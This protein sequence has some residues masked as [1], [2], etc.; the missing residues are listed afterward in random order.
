MN[1]KTNPWLLIL[2][3]APIPVVLFSFLLLKWYRQSDEFARLTSQFV[4]RQNSVLAY[5]AGEVSTGV[6]DLLEK[7]ARDVEILSLLPHDPKRYLQFHQLQMSDFTQFTSKADVPIQEP[8]NFYNK[9]LYMTLSGEFSIF[10][11]RGQ[12]APTPK[13]LAACRTKDLC[14]HDLLERAL[15]LSVGQLEYGHLMRYY[16]P[17]SVPEDANNASW[18]IAYHGKDGIYFLGLDY[19]HLRDHM[20]TPSFP[21]DSKRDLMQSYQNGNYIYLVDADYNIFVHPKYW[22]SYGLDR[23][24]GLAVPSM[25]TDADE[26]KVFINIANYQSGRLKEYFNRLLTRSF[27]QKGV[28]IF[29]AS[30][31]VGTTRVL[32]VTP[33][34]LSKGQFKRTGV[35]GYV[36]VGCS[37]DYFEEPKEK[38]IPYY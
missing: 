26:G 14:D 35:F 17:Q 23:A 29:Q 19:R 1:R 34:L 7:S 33:I 9:I 21:Y 4:Q 11:D 22:N 24:T 12:L 10:V 37:I 20:T 3:T 32:S 31:L 30:N 18:G 8:L 5:D 15:H 6:S 36:I 38:M 28:D 25:K 27:V 16:S 13:N 2:L